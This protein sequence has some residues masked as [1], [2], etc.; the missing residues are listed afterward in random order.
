[1]GHCYQLEGGNEAS[2]RNVGQ[3]G[4]IAAGGRYS[5]NYRLLENKKSECG[6]GL[7]KAEVMHMDVGV[8][9]GFLWN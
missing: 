4:G 2:A 8:F 9:A 3:G 5:R 1:M 6:G 7:M